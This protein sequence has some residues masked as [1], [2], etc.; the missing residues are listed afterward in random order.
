MG[1]GWDQGQD[2]DFALGPGRD[3]PSRSRGQ[4]T[5]DYITIRW[6]LLVDLGIDIRNQPER[7]TL[8]RT[9]NIGLRTTAIFE[10]A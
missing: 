5:L 4:S 7:S 6:I 3:V 8:D 10:T 1:L 2:L 9:T